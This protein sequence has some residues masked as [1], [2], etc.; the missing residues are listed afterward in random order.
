MKSGFEPG[1]I[2]EL[3]YVAE[4][5][6]LVGLG[7]AAFRDFT[8]YV[9]YDESSPFPA[10]RAVATGASQAGR[11]LRHFFQDGFDLDEA[12]R[13]VFDGALILI[14]GAGKGGFNHRFS[15][16]GRV[17]NPYENF[18]YPGDDFPFASRSITFEGES[19]GV[20]ENE[21]ASKTTPRM[22]RIF[23]IN[24]GYE[25]WG[26]GASLVHMTPDGVGDVA[27]LPNERLYHIASAPHYPLPFPPI[28]GSEVAPGIYR[29]SSVDTSP[30]QRAMLDHLIAWIETDTP[31]PPSQIPHIADGTLVPFT[32]VEYPIANL[33]KPRSPHVAYR[34]DF[35]PRFDAGIIDFQPPKRGNAYAVRVP[36]VDVFGS[37]ATGIRPLELLAPIGT[38]TPWALRTGYEFAS[39]EMIGYL[40]SF[41][42]LACEATNDAI[43]ARPSLGELYESQTDYEARVDAGI[44][45]MVEAGWMLE[46]DTDFARR[47]ALARWDWISG[48]RCAKSN[49]APPR[50]QQVRDR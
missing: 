12:G 42:P 6:P 18:F 22:P 15:H 8:S 5:P 13:P 1:W 2:Y 35:G 10:A 9:R 23:Q 41:I 17:G 45:S 36:T 30:I 3:V 26:R 25:Y 16:P 20:F 11:F 27:P 19:G 40:G 33:R 24:T 32:E 21:R 48:V 34:L 14:A 37:E 39:N 46:A 38:Y 49:D 7:F 43:D 29:G 44:E 4:S 50:D 28:P 47:A 31:P